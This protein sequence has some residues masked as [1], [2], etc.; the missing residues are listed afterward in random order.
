VDDPRETVEQ[1][2]HKMTEGRDPAT[3]FIALTG[4]TIAIAVVVAVLIAVALTL[5]YVYGGK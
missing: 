4:V 1:A 5:Y 2:A 3:P